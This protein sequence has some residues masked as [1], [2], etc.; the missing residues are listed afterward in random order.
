MNGGSRSLLQGALGGE[1]AV[2]ATISTSRRLDHVVKQ[3]WQN[4][5]NKKKNLRIKN[6]F[7]KFKK[8]K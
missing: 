1:L 8:K 3:R 7:K 2:I 6:F 4:A 5:P